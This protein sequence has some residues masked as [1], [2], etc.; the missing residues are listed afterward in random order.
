[1]KDDSSDHIT[2]AFSV[3][4]YSG[5]MVMTPSF[6]HLSITFSNQRFSNCS[7]TVDVGMV[8][9]MSGSFY[10]N[11]VFEM[12]IQFYCHLCCRRSVFF[13]KKI[14]FNIR[15]SLSIN[16]NFCPLFLFADVA[17]PWFVYTDITLETVA[18][19]TPN[20]VAVFVADGPAKRAP[21]ICPLSKL[22][23]SP[24]FRFFHTDCNSTQSLMNLH[25]HYI[26]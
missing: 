4:W 26:V 24:T 18:L 25:E 7:P 15:R 9:L 13:R 14:L 12:N 22:Y 16:V 1:V 23:N 19:V 6:T 20:N 10:G 21:T 3:V 17:F 5:F 2:R 8:K 11:R